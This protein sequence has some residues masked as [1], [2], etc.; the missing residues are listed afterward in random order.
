MRIGVG[1]T[2]GACSWSMEM[3]LKIGTVRI[4][5]DEPDMFE[6][7]SVICWDMGPAGTDTELMFITD[8]VSDIKE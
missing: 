6:Q 8:V 4:S 2:T 5:T 7:C 1:A 3:G